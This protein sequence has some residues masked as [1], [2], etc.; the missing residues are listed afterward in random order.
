MKSIVCSI[1]LL[2]FLTLFGVI[3]ITPVYSAMDAVFPDPYECYRSSATITSRLADLVS[4]YPTLARLKTIGQSFEGRPIQVL[5]LGREVETSTKPKLVVVSGLQANALA[6]VELNVLFAEK[7]L[8]S[9]GSDPNASWLLDQT[10]VHLL[11]TANPDGRQFAEQQ[12]LNGN[13]PT[14]T[15][16]RNP[17]GCSN[18]NG[19][20]VL[21]TNFSYAWAAISGNPCAPNYPGPTAASEPETLAIQSY[22]SQI[23]SHNPEST[24][25]LDLETKGDHLIT[26]YLFS[27]TAVNPLEY[28]LYMLANKLLHNN[29][30]VPLRGSSSQIGILTGSL[31]DFA[32]ANLHAP[33]L[34]F[35]MGNELA[36]GDAAYC[37]YFN[38]YL[39]P[40]GLRFLTRAAMLTANPL[41]QAQGPETTL[42]TTAFSFD[43]VQVSGQAD[44]MT[45]YKLWLNVGE[46]SAVHHIS[47]SLDT[48][49]WRADAV[50]NQVDWEQPSPGG[51]FA[52]DFSHTF[53][54]WEMTPGKHTAYFQAWDTTPSGGAGQGGMIDA[55]EL[56]VP[57]FQFIPMIVR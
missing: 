4:L 27:K 7:L 20:V 9:Y 8:E 43:S 13:A 40:E 57:W 2:L 30:A 11:I 32:F 12:M 35:R 19:G 1:K 47:F 17:H 15:K 25:V 51:S 49:P 44:D 54:L 14:W 16:S 31:T 6:P 26:P 3:S 18:G 22:L 34:H 28:D 45:F 41:A 29:Q 21:G 50:L 55:V 5:Q 42:T 46:Y 10:E 38:D 37:W 24:L 23:L 52:K 36:G 33:A 53:H 48:P 39:K 56:Y